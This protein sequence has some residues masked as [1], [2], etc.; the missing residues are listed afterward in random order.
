MYCEQLLDEYKLLYGMKGTSLRIF[1][2][3]GAGL[4]RQVVW[5][6]C[7][8]ALLGNKEIVLY[9]TGA[10][11]RDFVHAEDVAMAVCQV[12]DQIERIARVH[13]VALRDLPAAVQPTGSSAD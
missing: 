4:R 7:T 8:K 6:I 3:Y 1:S 10:E 12:A 2:A 13:I 9:G 11:T 5:D